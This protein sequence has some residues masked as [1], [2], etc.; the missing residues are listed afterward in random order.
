[1][2]KILFLCIAIFNYSLLCSMNIDDM[3]S[4]LNEMA[5][6]DDEL[7]ADLAKIIPAEEADLDLTL[8]QQKNIKELYALQQKRKEKIAMIQ[9]RFEQSKAQETKSKRSVTFNEILPKVANYADQ[10]AEVLS[11]KIDFKSPEAY[12]YSDDYDETES[13][14]GLTKEFLYIRQNA[15]A[16]VTRFAN[17]ALQPQWNFANEE[18]LTKFYKE[19]KEKI[20]PRRQYEGNYYETIFKDVL[21]CGKLKSNILE[22]INDLTATE[23][24]EKFSE[25]ALRAQNIQTAFTKYIELFASGIAREQHKIATIREAYHLFIEKINSFNLN[26]DHDSKNFR[27]FIHQADGVDL[28]RKEN[29]YFEYVFMQLVEMARFIE[30]IPDDRL[31]SFGIA[32]KQAFQDQSKLEDPNERL[33]AR[34]NLYGPLSKKLLDEFNKNNIAIE[35]WKNNIQKIVMN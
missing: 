20:D 31:N 11:T 28:R 17:W 16:A 6:E 18:S 32:I 1:M 30:R 2:K 24:K 19:L 12:I 8:D 4:E 21:A 5:E 9:N 26:N 3:V 27:A 7:A 15:L 25:Y 33:R 10:R 13:R 14:T 34:Q 23:L 35:E 22:K 29:H